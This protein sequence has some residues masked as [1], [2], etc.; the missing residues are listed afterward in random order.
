MATQKVYLTVTAHPD[1]EILGFGGAT[2]VL[3]NQGHKVFNCI[4]SG[5]VDVRSNRPSDENLKL[6]TY[7]AQKIVGANPP[8]LG[9]FPNIKFNTVPHLDLVQFIEKA[10]EQIN[11][12][13]IITH[14]PYD[15]NNDHYHTSKACQAAARLYQRRPIKP[16]QSLYFMEIPSSTDWSF[17]VDSQTFRPDTFIEI[18]EQ[19]LQKKLEAL[20]AYEGVMRP[21]PHPRS[22]EAIRALATIR[23]CQVGKILCEGLQTAMNILEY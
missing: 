7:K 1:D 15:L 12:D 6:H 16:L 21:Y 14:H 5:G 20:Y 3:S 13:V 2:Y 9:T 19:G 10:I 8:I 17:P 22:D 23:G 18:G 11:P 4:L